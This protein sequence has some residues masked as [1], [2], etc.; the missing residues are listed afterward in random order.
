MRI[1]AQTDDIATHTT[2]P[3]GRPHPDCLPERLQNS[4]KKTPS[5]KLHSD[6]V[7]RLFPKDLEFFVQLEDDGEQSINY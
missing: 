7:Y 4:I 2:G 5:E 3:A 1:P 6:F